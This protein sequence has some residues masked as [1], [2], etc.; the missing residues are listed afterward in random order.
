MAGNCGA[1]LELPRAASSSRELAA[2]QAGQLTGAASARQ[3]LQVHG[4]KNAG[5]PGG[6]R[7]SP[8]VCEHRSDRRE[9]EPPPAALGKPIQDTFDLSSCSFLAWRYHPHALRFPWA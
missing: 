6:V 9:Q 5:V 2:Q 7:A 1:D 8:E 3:H 4:A